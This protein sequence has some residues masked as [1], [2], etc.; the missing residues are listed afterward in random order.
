MVPR[1]A[2]GSRARAEIEFLV[3]RGDAAA[4]RVVVRDEPLVQEVLGLEVEV[5]GVGRA[6]RIPGL[7]DH[8]AGVEVVRGARWAAAQ[9]RNETIDAPPRVG[10]GP[11]EGE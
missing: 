5:E 11:A 6:E 7:P 1:D 2:D 4:L 8:R 3:L 10:D 9:L